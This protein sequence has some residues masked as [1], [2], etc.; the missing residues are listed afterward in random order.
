MRSVTSLSGLE[1]SSLCFHIPIYA[2]EIE[3]LARESIELHGPLQQ[4]RGGAT[5]ECA[6]RQNLL[7]KVYENFVAELPAHPKMGSTVG[8]NSSG[9]NDC[10]T[11]TSMGAASTALVP[12]FETPSSPAF[13]S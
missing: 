1:P 3:I 9:S 12:I 5:T 11:G 6:E 10:D 4:L 8:L 13:V 7:I 2:L